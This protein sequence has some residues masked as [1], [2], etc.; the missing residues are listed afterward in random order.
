[1][2]SRR[3]QVSW[4]QPNDYLA[5]RRHCQVFHNII[6]AETIEDAEMK[7][8]DLYKPGEVQ[9]ANTEEVDEKGNTLDANRSRHG[10]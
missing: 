2:M 1:M 9:I 10:A 6:I 4:V 7:F 3:F 8:F 5:H